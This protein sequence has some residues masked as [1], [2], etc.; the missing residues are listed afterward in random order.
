MVIVEPCVETIKK[1]KDSGHG[2]YS[3][4]SINNGLSNR[5]ENQIHILKIAKCDNKKRSIL[6]TDKQSE[7]TKMKDFENCTK[8]KSHL[9]MYTPKE[10]STLVINF[11]VVQIYIFVFF[12]SF[13]LH[14]GYSKSSNSDTQICK[15]WKKA[16]Q[17]YKILYQFALNLRT[18]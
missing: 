3:C 4:H 18:T 7:K 17:C 16:K 15:T 2:M 9:H 5:I 12:C 14:F 11:C 8:T 1:Q 13:F 6:L 10:L